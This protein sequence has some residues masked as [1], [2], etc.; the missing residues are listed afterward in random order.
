MSYLPNGDPAGMGRRWLEVEWVEATALASE[1]ALE[2]ALARN[3]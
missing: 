3:E 1:T 2:P